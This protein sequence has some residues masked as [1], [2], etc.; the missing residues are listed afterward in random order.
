MTDVFIKWELSSAEE[1]LAF[2][3][4]VPADAVVQESRKVLVVDLFASKPQDLSLI[5]G[6]RYVG[7]AC[8]RH[9]W[10]PVSPYYPTVVITIRALE[11]YRV[12]HLR[13][14]RLG[15]QAFTRALCDIH[16]VAPRPWLASQ[17]SVAFDVYLAI[18]A[19]VQVVLAR[20]SPNW[21][22]KNAC[23]PC[24]YKLEGEVQLEIP[25]M[26][27]MDGNNS[28]SRFA[29]RER[30]EVFADGTTAPGQSKER[31]D[32]HTVLGD[33]YLSREEVDKWAKGLEDLM[34]DF[35]DDEEGVDEGEERE[36]GCAERWQN[37]KETVTAHA[38][39]SAAERS[40]VI[41]RTE[42]HQY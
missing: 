39:G 26:C 34:K 42:A 31:R 38:W 33:Y 5:Q 21:C 6:D 36:S 8:V 15:I 35:E 13:C 27:T 17:F 25:F 3:Y 14:P 2:E 30:E 7:S 20:D 4:R 28:L 29:M 24:L 18:R 22:L 19:R 16:G 9:G 1:G 23:P 40:A 41:T 11:M 12:T 37:M 32:N 10:M